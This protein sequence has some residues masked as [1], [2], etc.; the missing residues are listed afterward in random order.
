L[1]AGPHAEALKA[2]NLGVAAHISAAS[3]RGPRYD[4]S[5]HPSQ[6]CSAEN[7]IWLCQLCGKLVDSDVVRYTTTVLNRWKSAAEAAA[8]AELQS[9]SGLPRFSPMLPLQRSSVL[10]PEVFAGVDYTVEHGRG[11]AIDYSIYILALEELISVGVSSVAIVRKSGPD[12]VIPHLPVF[13]RERVVLIEPDSPSEAIRR[14]FHPIEEEFRASLKFPPTPTFGLTFNESRLPRQLGITLAWIYPIVYKLYLGMLYGL[15]IEIDVEQGLSLCG[16]LREQL[17]SPD[18]RAPFAVVAGLLSAYKETRIDTVTFS[19]KATYDQ[20]T[21]RFEQLFS[22]ESYSGLS[23]SAFDLGHPTRA[24]TAEDRVSGASARV[25]ST[26]CGDGILSKSQLPLHNW[27]SK[28]CSPEL[29]PQ[30]EHC[31]LPPVVPF[32][33]VCRNA[34]KLWLKLC[35][36]PL[37]PNSAGCQEPPAVILRRSIGR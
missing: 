31:Y 1:T 10:L 4:P 11:S 5:L 36:P 12:A 32:D 14:L 33:I 26:Q 22:M 25:L 17:R 8:F 18:A 3:L 27:S 28:C 29:I 23:E 30:L 9:P 21:R 15:H 20:R 6:R 2:V 34:Q 19:T 16:R 37:L 24:E 13:M 7:G 35:L